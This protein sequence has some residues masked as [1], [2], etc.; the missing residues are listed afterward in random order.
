MR[1]SSPVFMNQNGHFRN[2]K[3]KPSVYC[4]KNYFYAR[5]KTTSQIQIKY[6]ESN[7]DA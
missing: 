5:N 2:C 4:K 3:S 7:P 1:K 6:Y